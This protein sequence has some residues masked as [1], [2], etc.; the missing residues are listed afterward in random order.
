MNY[1]WIDYWTKKTGLAINVWNIA[2]PYKIITNKNII[3]QLKEIINEKK[4][5][6]FIVWM[7]NL[8]S[9]DESEHSKKIKSF[10]GVLKKE[11]WIEVEFVDERYS[12][13]DARI[14]LETAWEKRYDSK[15]LDD[16]AATIILQNYLDLWK[17]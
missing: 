8:A 7:A 13:F 5:N 3:K 1:L 2:F 16:I 9:W 10:S 17:K 14:S 4:I 12:S 11:F 15:K 6:K